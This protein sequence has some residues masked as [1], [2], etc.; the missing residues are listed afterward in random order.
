MYFK[1]TENKGTSQSTWASEHTYNMM[2]RLAELVEHQ[3]VPDA[4]KE[5]KKGV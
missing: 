5:T 4:A 2:A 3:A 1:N